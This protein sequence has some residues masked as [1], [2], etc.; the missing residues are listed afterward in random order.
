MKKPLV[1]VII[2][3]FN[4]GRYF[5]KTLKSLSQQTYINF[6]VIVV[7]KGSS[8]RTEELVH[9]YRKVIK[10]LSFYTAGTERTSQFNFGVSKSKG[11]ILYYI[12]SDYAL[13]DKVIEKAAQ[14]IEEGSDAVIIEQDSVGSSFW[15]KVRRLERSTYV[16]DDFIEASRFFTRKIYDLIGG[17]DSSLVAYEEHDLQN[18]LKDANAKITRTKGV[19]E[20]HLGEPDNLGQIISKSF[21]YGTTVEKYF[22]KHRAMGLRHASLIRP[23]YFRHWRKLVA[24]PLLLG[25][26][27]VMTFSKQGAGGAGYLYAKIAKWI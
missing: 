16:G 21:Y 12:G 20:H 7:D 25:G 4:S 19:V 17:Y 22:A 26:L 14:Q 2:P 10:N 13:E 11:K 24:H 18:R 1:S 15:A 3:T 8:D 27:I 5:E 9:K 6:E 23:S